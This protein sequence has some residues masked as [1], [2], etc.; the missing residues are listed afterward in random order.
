MRTQRPKI[1]EHFWFLMQVSH[2]SPYHLLLQQYVRPQWD[3]HRAKNARNIWK[4]VLTASVYFYCTVPWLTLVKMHTHSHKF[5]FGL[6]KKNQIY[7]LALFGTRVWVWLALTWKSESNEC[8]ISSFNIFFISW[9][10]LS[11]FSTTQ[12]EFCIP[13]SHPFL[14]CICHILHSEWVFSLHWC[15]PPTHIYSAFYP[16]KSIFLCLPFI[17]CPVFRLLPP[18]HLCGHAL[19][20][21]SQLFNILPVNL[22]LKLLH[23]GRWSFLLWHGWSPP[24]ICKNT[25]FAS[26]DAQLWGLWG[27]FAQGSLGKPQGP[28]TS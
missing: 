2:S 3:N 4:T 19:S 26:E 16:A 22:M 1:Y 14:L 15:V 10:V 28:V 11:V 7:V 17:R 5:I 6:Y 24:N 13:L 9:L 23:V 18:L 8:L 21:F 12:L 25:A 20:I 27:G